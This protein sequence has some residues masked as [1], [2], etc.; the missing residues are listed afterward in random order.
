MNW[1]V[2]RGGGVEGPFTEAQVVDGI[3][4]G[5]V[6]RTARVCPEGTQTWV[7]V[8][9]SQFAGYL[10]SVAGA[11]PEKAFGMPVGLAVLGALLIVVAVLMV[12]HEPKKAPPPLPEVP[13]PIVAAPPVPQEPSLRDRAIAAKTL[14]GAIALLVPLMDDTTGNLGPANA[15]LAEWMIA[16]AVTLKEIEA[17]PST[18]AARVKKDSAAE[19]GKRLCASGSIVEISVDRSAGTPVFH[20]GMTSEDG[21][22]RFTVVRSTGTLV[23]SSYARICGVLSGRDDYDNSAGGVTHAVRVVG[24]FDLPENR[25]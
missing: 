3:Q 19:R 21:I 25:K 4:K 15:V 24:L 23:E 9:G 20:G 8:T 17:L 16:H 6:P 1:F 10:P 11:K 13:T 18:T 22:V 2:E 7:P 5:G 14:P 12:L